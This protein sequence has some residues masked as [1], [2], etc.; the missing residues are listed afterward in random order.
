MARPLQHADLLTVR[1]RPTRRCGKVRPARPVW[2]SP[3]VMARMAWA[4]PGTTVKVWE[5]PRRDPQ[6]W[7][8]SG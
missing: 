1:S 8:L 4:C 3:V 5:G 2:S 7:P 6:A